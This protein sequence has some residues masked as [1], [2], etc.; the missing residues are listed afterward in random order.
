MRSR[1]VRGARNDYGLE[2]TLSLRKPARW[3]RLTLGEMESLV[4]LPQTGAL[5]RIRSSSRFTVAVLAGWLMCV[6]AATATGLSLR[7]SGAK[8]FAPPLFG[9]V[10][11]RLSLH[12]APAVGFGIATVLGGVSIARRLRWSLL[13]PVVL[14][15]AGVWAVLLAYVDGWQALSAPLLDGHDYLGA[16]ATIVSPAAFLRTFTAQLSSYSTHVQGHPPGMVLVL[17][18]ATRAGLGPGAAAA[19][20][21]A[22]GA[23][24]VVATLIALRNVSGERAA[25]RCAPFLVVAPAA[26]WIA[27]SADALFLGLSAWGVAAM[28]VASSRRDARGDVLA[29]VGGLALGG[30]LFLSYGVAPLGAVVLAVLV[31]RRRPRPLLVGAGCVLVVAATFY[32]FG[33]SWFEGL[34]ATLQRYSAGVSAS[35]PAGYFAFA[36]LVAFSI[37]VGPACVVGI[38]RQTR[39]PAALL[40][41]AALVAVAVADVSGFTKGEVERIWLPYAPWVLTSTAAVSAGEETGLLASQTFVALLVQVLVRTP[42]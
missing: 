2:K 34:G 35:R 33:F 32:A 12:A 9:H 18:A 31:W 17:W 42:W 5:G 21:I 6:C 28:V 36:D 13:L 4:D 15:G 10:D 16:A 29:L 27:T 1:S 37:V 8:L 7:G 30:C 20:I 40:A 14:A 11:F 24:S 38:A 19:G 23:S 3:R 39:G 22:A 26:I 41:G 25:R